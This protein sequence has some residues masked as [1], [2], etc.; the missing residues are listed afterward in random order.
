MGW[1]A[2]S[3]GIRD[4]L[5]GLTFFRT[6]FWLFP[7]WSRRYQ[8][9]QL[10]AQ[11]VEHLRGIGVDSERQ[12]HKGT[13]RRAHEDEYAV[14]LR[15]LVTIRVWLRAI[16]SIEIWR[17][18]RK[19]DREI[20]TL[21]EMTFVMTPEPGMSLNR[22]PILTNLIRTRTTKGKNRFKWRGF[23][24]GRL[25]LL[26]DRLKADTDL[27]N[28]L[29]GYFDSGMVDDLRITALD[30]ERIGITTSYSPQQLP[31]RGFL[32]CIDDIAEHISDYVAEQNRTREL[33][34]S[35]SG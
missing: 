23:E 29:L 28:R 25:P 20:V 35:R 10:E 26:V 19:G 31:S 30:G 6:L 8:I 3:I 14:I 22:I 15:H 24:W 1:R 12:T 9:R 2:F 7:R 4:T 33:Q 27:N 32:T 18:T 21:D 34:S 16:R 5:A 13:V 11:L 17:I